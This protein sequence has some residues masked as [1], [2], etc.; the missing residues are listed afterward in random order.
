MKTLLL[1]PPK[2]WNGMHVSRE[3]YGIGLVPTDFL[4][5]G[6]FLAAA[7]LCEKGRDAD[8]L[9]AE[10]PDISF[11]GYDV[12]VV[13][14]CI[15][16]SFYEDI[17]YL[18]KAK[19]AGKKTIM[20][21]NDAH[22]GLE[23]EAMQRFDFID[24]AVRLWEREIALD[25]LL[26]RWEENQEPDFPG[27]IFR[28]GEELVDTGRMPFLPN[29]E[30]LPSCSKVLKEVSLRRY[31]SAA[32]TS[33][34][35][36]PMT[37]PFCLYHR[38]GL[39]RRKVQD[40]VS[41]LETI[42]PSL[43]DIVFIDVSM[44]ATHK[45]MEELC[46]QLLARKLKLSWRIDAKEWQCNP[47]TLAKLKRAGCDAIMLV[48]L[49]LDSETSGQERPV[50]PPQQMKTAI[51]NLK[52]ARISP[53]PVFH[54]GFPWDSN[55]TLLRIKDFLKETPAP[56]FFLKQLRPWRGTPL[57]DECRNLGL[58]KRELGIDDYVHSDY[59]LMD[60][61]YLSKQEVEDWKY[62]IQ[63]SVVLDFRYMQSFLRERGLP[64][65]K[66]VSQFLRLTIGRK[67]GAVK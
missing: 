18:R 57:Y 63:S 50:T 31:K 38:T 48:V 10:T 8:A 20:V 61:L 7:Y 21:L 32:I 4:P 43:R 5:S 3:E 67:P 53:V 33:G 25:K 55:E 13:W 47:E 66:Q 56:S 37:H 62:H 45:W 52:K 41:E 51:E 19:E 29:L 17:Q 2:R 30:H 64:S 42:S 9:D 59:P 22:D 46:D 60:T 34:R 1:N 14:A 65:P 35:G 15:L 27:V 54:V 26:S 58:V 44:P 36:C 39:R 24:A 16:H 6:I 12:V 28:K 49:T 11:E 40:V 23:M